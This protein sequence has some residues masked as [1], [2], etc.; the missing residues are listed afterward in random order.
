MPM[1]PELSNREK[2]IL[3]MLIDGF[4]L[5]DIARELERSIKTITTHKLRI[6]QKLGLKTYRDWHLFYR[7]HPL[8]KDDGAVH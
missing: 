8:A 4:R 5:T 1:K 3:K 2:Q 6:G 7:T